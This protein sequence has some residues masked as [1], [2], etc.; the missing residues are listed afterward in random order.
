MKVGSL[1]K[2][3]TLQAKTKASDGGGSFTVTWKDMATVAC[4]IWPI[5]AKEQ[6]ASM[7]QTMVIS[8]RIRM[9]YRSDV[10]PS[11]RIKYRNIYY[12]IVSIIDINM[13]H[14][15]LEILAKQVV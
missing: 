15:T 4:S 7:G 14:V 6:V 13:E 8:H 3:V 2:R 5:S 12:N 9:R 10:K 11:W 1:N